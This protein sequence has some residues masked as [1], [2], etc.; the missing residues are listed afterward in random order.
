[1]PQEIE[2]FTAEYRRAY[3]KQVRA[4]IVDESHP[5]SVLRLVFELMNKLS[6]TVSGWLEQQPRQPE[7][8]EECFDILQ[9]YADS[10]RKRPK[11]T[12]K[13]YSWQTEEKH[14]TNE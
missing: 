7:T 1:M 3:L 4:R 14:K 2:R 12:K 13:E 8:I 11:A 9:R 10:K 6:A 5:T